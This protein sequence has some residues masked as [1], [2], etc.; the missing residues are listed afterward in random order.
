MGLVI[1]SS[2]LIQFERHAGST[3]ELRQV[4]AEPLA[5]SAITISELCFGLY[6][7]DSSGRRRRRETFIESILNTLPVLSFDLPAARVHAEIWS[8]LAA[9]GQMIGA[10]DLIIS[11][12]AMSRG[13]G[14]L[15]ANVREFSRVSGLEVRQLSW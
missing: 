10:H 4:A 7:A 8:S 2:V 6:R 15:T 5:I 1:D 14:V 11:A 13:F 12:T 9:A 3:G